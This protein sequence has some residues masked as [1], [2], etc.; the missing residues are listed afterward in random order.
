MVMRLAGS[1]MS[2]FL[3]R[4]LQVVLIVSQM[5]ESRTGSAVLMS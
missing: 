4:S 5:S 1:L 2:I 3:I